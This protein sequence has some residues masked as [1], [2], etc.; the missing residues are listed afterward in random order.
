MDRA[1][2]D[3]VV[4]VPPSWEGDR[5]DIATL[6]QVLALAQQPNVAAKV[7]AMPCYVGDKT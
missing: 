3:R 1:G 4:I 5:N 6:N 2:I 7:S